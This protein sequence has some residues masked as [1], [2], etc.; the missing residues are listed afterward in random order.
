M[1]I[2]SSEYD[3]ETHRARDT[4]SATGDEN[5]E[6]GVDTRPGGL[7][8]A[9][10]EL[11]VFARELRP[12]VRVLWTPWPAPYNRTTS[13]RPRVGVN[14]NL[15]LAMARS[16]WK[17]EREK[18]QHLEQ[19]HRRGQRQ[20]QQSSKDRAGNGNGTRRA[21]GGIDPDD[22]FGT[23]HTTG[24]RAQHLN[25]TTAARPPIAVFLLN[26]RRGRFTGFGATRFAE[27]SPLR[28]RQFVYENARGL[29]QSFEVAE[30]LRA[31]EAEQR[32]RQQSR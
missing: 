14:D 16:L 24:E 19:Q 29:L 9:L 22:P 5:D 31:E 6:A 30:A 18:Q 1:V 3:V 10:R 8:R 32:H 15:L 21:Q 20:R 28:L 26:V 11:E 4:S 25:S 2:A 7:R 13:R 17:Q 23:R 27:L 12:S